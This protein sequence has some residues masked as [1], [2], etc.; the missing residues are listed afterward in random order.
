MPLEL[1][2]SGMNLAER[3]VRLRIAGLWQI[4]EVSSQRTSGSGLRTVQS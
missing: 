4:D 1:T 2:D 3:F